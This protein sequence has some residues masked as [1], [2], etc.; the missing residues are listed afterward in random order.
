MKDETHL[1][2]RKKGTRKRIWV[3]KSRNKDGEG[4]D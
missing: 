4:R 3:P 1:T 2:G